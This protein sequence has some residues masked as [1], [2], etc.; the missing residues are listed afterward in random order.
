MKKTILIILGILFVGLVTAIAI[1]IDNINSI[2]PNKQ[3]KEKLEKYYYDME[4]GMKNVK[5]YKKSGQHIIISFNETP[6]RVFTS[7]KHFNEVING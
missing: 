2:I 7:K 6:Y 4:K 1:N 3:Q 5:D